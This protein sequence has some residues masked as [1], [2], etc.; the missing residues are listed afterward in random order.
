M[1]FMITVAVMVIVAIA[2]VVTPLLRRGRQLGRPRGVFALALII[3]V[4]VPLATLGLYLKIGTPITLDGVAVQPPP[5]NIDQALTDLRAHLAQQPDDLRGWLL[6]AQTSTAMHQASDARDAY[7]HVLKLDPDN[8]DAMVGWAEADAM[9]QSTHVIGERAR[10]LLQ[11]AVIKQPDNQRALWLLGIS[12]FQQNQFAEAATTWRHLQPMLQAGSA[13]ATAVAGQ[14]AAA[15]ERAGNPGA[16]ASVAKAPTPIAST[17]ADTS[18]SGPALQVHVTL[19]TALKARV[20]RG[21]ILFIYARAPNGPPMP[22]AVARMD[23]NTLPVSITLTDAM[24]MTPQ[25]KLSSVSKA[26]I[27]A[28]ISHSGQAIAQPGDLE[29]DAGVLAVD[30]QK[31]VNITIDKVH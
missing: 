29:G 1:V 27:G 16:D 7:D 26:F 12:Q 22:L 20:S 23:A 5:M 19:A 9:L 13:V 18:R 24:A 28:R 15:D 14:I 31:P 2:A 8:T 6:L 10:D 17:Q 4:V 25:L 30:P 3:I 21:D 11:Q